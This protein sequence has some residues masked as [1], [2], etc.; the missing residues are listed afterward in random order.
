VLQKTNVK[1]NNILKANKSMQTKKTLVAVAMIAL[2]FLAIAC[3]K[4]DSGG[5]N[6]PSGNQRQVRFEVTGNYTGT[7]TAA[8]T[9]ASG[10]TTVEDI[11]SLP[12]RKDITYVASVMGT[13]MS[14]G[15]STGSA[16]QTITLKIFSGGTEV[17]ST[18]AV[19]NSSGVI[20]V[21]AP[22]LLFR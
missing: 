10:G 6:P 3:N 4:E 7:L 21:S 13:G 5:T 19:A 20:S 9:T 16:Q 14:V 8:F 22:A 18:P 15:G 12:W 17:S 11:T 2:S 1:N